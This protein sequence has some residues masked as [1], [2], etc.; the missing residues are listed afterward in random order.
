[1]PKSVESRQKIFKYQVM[2]IR[3]LFPIALLVIANSTLAFKLASPTSFNQ[4]QNSNN[5]V[6]Q[7]SVDIRKTSDG[8]LIAVVKNHEGYPNTI[9]ALQTNDENSVPNPIIL[10]NAVINYSINCVTF[11]STNSG[12]IVVFKLNNSSCQIPPTGNIRTF[13]GYGLIKQQRESTYN[14]L[15]G[16]AGTT[17]PP[18][19]EIVTC[20]CNT[21]GGPLGGIAESGCTS[22]GSGSTTCSQ[23]DTSGSCSVTCGTGTYACCTQH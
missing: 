9:F 5:L 15:I 19:L 3:K 1:M 6:E 16:F 18:I 7:P 17:F 2:F 14:S 11:R 22:G 12:N 23:S 4:S 21:P 10:T 13:T 8:A 20:Q